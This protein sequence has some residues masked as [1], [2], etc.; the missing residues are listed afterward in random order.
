MKKRIKNPAFYQYGYHFTGYLQ[1]RSILNQEILKI[2]EPSRSF[3]GYFFNKK[4]IYFLTKDDVKFLST[5]MQQYIVGYEY[6]LKIEVSNYNQYPDFGSLQD[7]GVE[8]QKKYSK[9]LSHLFY[10]VKRNK[11]HT[12][13]L[14]K[15]WFSILGEEIP[16][17]EF[18][19]NPHLIKDCIATTHSFI[20]LENIPIKKIIEII[21][22]DRL[23]FYKRKKSSILI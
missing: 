18:K 22:I 23:N 19:T 4:P 1:L 21:E 15:K 16:L 10:I 6:L 9:D 7:Y 8:I 2:D 13:K 20:T 3:E 11:K 5:E 14:L 12:P 17:T